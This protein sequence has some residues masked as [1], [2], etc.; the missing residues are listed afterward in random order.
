MHLGHIV[1]WDQG[2]FGFVTKYRFVLW[3]TQSNA[4]NNLSTNV[5]QTG[6]RKEMCRLSEYEK[7]PLFPNTDSVEMQSI[8]VILSI[9]NSVM[10]LLAIFGN[11]LILAA[12]WK[13]PSL[14]SPSYVLISVLALSDLRV[15]LILQ[16]TFVITITAR[17]LRYFRVSCFTFKILGT[18]ALQFAGVSYFTIAA[19]SFE[20]LLALRLHLRY[21]ELVTNKRVLL[22][23]ALFCKAGI[24]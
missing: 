5:T 15:G 11:T 20:R 8:L 3:R 13:N 23:V 19:T 7:F 22:V 10:A 12:V 6:I 9:I 16:P 1:S 14:R 17:A 2:S 21:Q 24:V 4:M 18:S